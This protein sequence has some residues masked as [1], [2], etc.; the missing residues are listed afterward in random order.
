MRSDTKIE[1]SEKE[2]RLIEELRKTRWQ[3]VKYGE[4]GFH[5]EASKIVDISVKERT[6]VRH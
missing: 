4:V 5:I 1:L 2:K 3:E 6:R